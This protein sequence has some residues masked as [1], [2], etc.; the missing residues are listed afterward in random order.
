M[1]IFAY[2]I[3]LIVVKGDRLKLQICK[4]IHAILVSFFNFRKIKLFSAVILVLRAEAEGNVNGGC[5][6][7]D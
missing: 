6:A 1:D 5:E 7:E 3:F 2:N 4:R